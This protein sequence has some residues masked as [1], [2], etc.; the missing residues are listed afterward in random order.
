[1]V[2]VQKQKCASGIKNLDVKPEDTETNPHNLLPVGFLT[3]VLK[4]C[5]G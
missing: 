1:M 3:K 2:L 4:L 5:A